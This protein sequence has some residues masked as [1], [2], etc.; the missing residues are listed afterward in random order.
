MVNDKWNDG[1]R[2]SYERLCKTGNGKDPEGVE[3]LAYTAVCEMYEARLEAEKRKKFRDDVV[4]AL[5]EMAQGICHLEDYLGISIR[6]LS[7]RRYA[8][9]FY[10]IR[11]ETKATCDA[12]YAAKQTCSSVDAVSVDVVNGLIDKV[13]EAMGLDWDSVVSYARDPTYGQG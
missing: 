8:E 4:A 3:G 2:A 12:L 6:D 13:R 11:K 1:E 7:S 9:Q 5:S 10:K